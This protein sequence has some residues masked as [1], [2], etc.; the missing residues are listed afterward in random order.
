MTIWSCCGVKSSVRQVSSTHLICSLD[1]RHLQDNCRG[2]GLFYMWTNTVNVVKAIV[3]VTL[4]KPVFFSFGVCE[5]LSWIFPWQLVLAILPGNAL[6]LLFF[7]GLWCSPRRSGEHVPLPWT[8]KRFGYGGHENNLMTPV[9]HTAV[10]MYSFLKLSSF[11]ELKTLP[12]SLSTYIYV[13][14][15]PSW[16]FLV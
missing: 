15:S 16:A 7:F 3:S 14:V 11:I 9:W 6:D 2:L 8:L 10:L 5:S 4:K 1:I 13:S 12:F